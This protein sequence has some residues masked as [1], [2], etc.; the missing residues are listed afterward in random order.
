MEWLPDMKPAEQQYTT[1]INFLD[2]ISV[3]FKNKTLS[4]SIW[5]GRVNDARACNRIVPR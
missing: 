1:E 3:I 2:G 4:G 5:L